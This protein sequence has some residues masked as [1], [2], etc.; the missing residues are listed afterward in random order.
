MRAPSVLAYTVAAL[1]ALAMAGAPFGVHRAV[2]AQVSPSSRVVAVV[3]ATIVNLGG[4]PG[5]ANAT[6]VIEGERITA[7]GPAASTTIPPGAEVIRANG[8][9]IS[10]GLMNMHTHYGLV[11]PGRQG[12]ELANE[13]EAALA[14]RMA[15]N[16]RTSLLTGV[17]TTRSTGEIK[18]ADFA[19]RR[20][21][22]RGEAVGPRIHTAGETLNVTGGHGW[23]P[24]KQGLDS[25]DDFRRAVRQRHSEGA[26]WIKI[27]ISGGIADTHGDIA[28][29]QM[30]KDEVAAVTETAHRLS[31]KVTAHS[32]SPG[33]TLEAIDAGLDCV[34]HGYFLTDAVLTKM[35]EKGVW[36]VPTIVVA[37][38]TVMEFFK[39]IGSPDWYLARV[40]SVGESHFKMLQNAIKHKVKIALGTDQFPYEPNDGTTA[41]VREAQYYVEA[42]MTP[43]Q[44]LRSATIEAATMLGIQDR[45]GAIEPG[46]LAD[47]VITE[48]DPSR[49]I[50]ALRGIRLVMKGG[51]VYRN[52]LPR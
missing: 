21:I 34:E 49:D 45:V 17:T 50:K 1:A 10:P 25:P 29:S 32:G 9:F 39:K 48:A 47:L 24:N 18:R 14:L 19:L 51:T 36:L 15:A 38:P 27:A 22:E 3:G 35:A 28:A 41:T 46:M 23:N 20:A 16:A 26:E 8:R 2:H 11:L 33:A 7:V 52:E 13:T 31:M 37:Q 40:A 6:V 4:G 44:A 5:V 43:L 12:A 30:T 42:G